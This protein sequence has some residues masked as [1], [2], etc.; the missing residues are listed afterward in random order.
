MPVDFDN[1][2]DAIVVGGYLVL[3]FGFGLFASKLLKTEGAEG[4][5]GYYLAG[6]KVPGWMNG[7][8]YAVTAMNADVAPTYA[9]FAVVVGLPIAWFY[10]PRFA[11]AWMLA[12]M[13]FAVRWR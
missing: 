9:G 12:A 11:L 5:E 1:V 10:L 4:E 7:I 2:I 8:S 6:R 3:S 13:L